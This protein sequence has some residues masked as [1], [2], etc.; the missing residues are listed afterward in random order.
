MIFIG[1][2][3]ARGAGHWPDR[4]AIVDDGRG[5][6]FTYRAM[7]DRANALAGWLRARGV[8]HGDR[9]GLLAHN[10]VEVLD[11]A[12]ACGKLGAVFVPF[13]WRQPPA[14]LAPLVALT[15][16]KVLVVGPE[17]A[18]VAAALP[19]P[20]L[21]LHTGVEYE[22]IVAAPSPPPVTRDRVDAEDDFCLLFTGGTT[23][24]PKAARVSY[25]MIAWNT[26]D[27]LVHEARS[28][29]VTITHTPMFHTGGLF[30]YTFPL[31][32]CGGRVVLMKRWDAARALELLEREEVTIFFA[33]PT[34][35][36][37]LAE[38]PGFA[39]ARLDRLR[40]LTSGGAALPIPTLRAWQAAHPVPFKQGFGMTEAGPG[41][42]SMQPEQA[43]AKAGSIGL[44]N[45]F[46]DARLV[47]DDGADVPPGEPGELLVRGP[48]LFSGYLGDPEATARAFSGEWFATG[49]IMRRDA[50]GFFFVV[51]RKKDM[52][53]SGGENVYP[54]E[55]EAALYQ[56]PAV[57]QCGVVGMP[58]A[59]WGEVGRAFIVLAPG[60]QATAEELTEHL[61]ARLARYKVPKR[62]DFV[63]ELPL[64]PAGKI[65]RRTLR[66]RP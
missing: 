52:F 27:T 41:L 34:Q 1:D 47:D 63:A 38:S 15:A 37:Q 56:H 43:A 46:V 11:L 9:V 16:I 18:A 31:L 62:I 35:H 28:G 42:F 29:D 54:A 3:M 25:R 50:D 19:E 60:A 53:I 51:D 45:Q 22:A 30:V 59:K 40:V 6:R 24:L 44:P 65:L 20:A 8:G 49:D 66:E 17:L 32:T 57:G 2:W 23:G 13:N 4:V 58:D 61:R 33:V 36:Q 5:E 21:R 14:E 7:D 39:G 48:V 64:S 55:I 26:L 12:F 10:G